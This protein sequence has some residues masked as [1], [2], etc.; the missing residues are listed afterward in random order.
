MACEQLPWQVFSPCSKARWWLLSHKSGGYLG[1]WRSWVMRSHKIL[2]D[3]SHKSG[4]QQPSLWR[5]FIDRPSAQVFGLCMSDV[6][7]FMQ[8]LFNSANLRLCWIGICFCQH[9]IALSKSSLMRTSVFSKTSQEKAC[10]RLL[11]RFLR[12]VHPLSHDTNNLRFKDHWILMSS[13]FNQPKLCMA[14][15]ISRFRH[16]LQLICTDFVHRPSLDVKMMAGARSAQCTGP[17]VTK[18][19][20]LRR[21]SW[22]HLQHLR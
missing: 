10:V 1:I 16:D 22:Y 11:W 14:P 8:G 13:K 2:H 19:F 18:L 17:G 6:I 20:Q 4:I 3:P 7:T 12:L 15:Q 5:C 9:V 21:W